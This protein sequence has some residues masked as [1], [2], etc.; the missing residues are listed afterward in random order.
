MTATDIPKQISAEE[1]AENLSDILDRVDE[2]RETFAVERN[3]VVIA[4]VGPAKP[5]FISVDELAAKIGHLRMPEGMADDLEAIHA[6]QGY[7]EI[8]EWPD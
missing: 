6:S 2:K 3:G 1:L 7:S 4:T 5:M 8:P